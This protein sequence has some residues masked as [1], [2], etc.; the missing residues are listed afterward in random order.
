MKLTANVICI[1]IILLLIGINIASAGGPPKLPMSIYGKVIDSDTNNIAPEGS[2]VKAVT[3]NGD[4]SSKTVKSSGWYGTPY[5]NR[6]LIKEC[7]SFELFIVVDG[8]ETSQGSYNWVSGD[9]KMINISFSSQE[10][11]ERKS[12]ESE[13]SAKEKKTSSSGYIGTASQ[14]T[15][16]SP[17]SI[18]GGGSLADGTTGG[19]K[20]AGEMATGH[21]EPSPTPEPT[22]KPRGESPT[23][24]ILV[25]FAILVGTIF[26]LYM[27]KR[28]QLKKQ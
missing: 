18:G 15:P 2:T 26:I 1:S 14:K 13:S 3:N 28:D 25:I 23:S 22:M 27:S 4:I 20:D 9:I 7:D 11:S 21:I 17:P 6:L 8:V 19:D 24:S 5:T 16:T 12:Q 10:V